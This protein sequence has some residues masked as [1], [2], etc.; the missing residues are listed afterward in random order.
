MNVCCFNRLLQ[1]PKTSWAPHEEAFEEM[2]K[3][4]KVAYKKY[5][6]ERTDVI[7]KEQSFLLMLFFEKHTSKVK[8]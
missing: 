6:H 4:A 3:I 8:F 1:D 2:T 5:L 7:A